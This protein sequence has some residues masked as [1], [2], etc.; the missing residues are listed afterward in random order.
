MFSNVM[1]IGSKS[2]TSKNHQR[3]FQLNENE[4]SKGDSDDLA[5]FKIFIIVSN[6]APFLA[7]KII[8]L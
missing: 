4:I 2:W 6:P 5:R 7:L 3:L 1:V 8:A